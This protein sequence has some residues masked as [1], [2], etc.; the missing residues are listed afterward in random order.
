MRRWS[1]AFVL[2]SNLAFAA[3]ARA[4]DP[5]TLTKKDHTEFLVVPD[6]GGDSDTGIEVG[7]GITLARFEK[8]YRPY[9][10]RIDVLLG[11]SFKVDPGFRLVQHRYSARLD[12][13]G[14][15]GGKLRLDTRLAYLR[16]G[17][18]SWFGEGN[19]SN[20]SE[21]PVAGTSRQRD[22][23]LDESIRL[24]T[25]GRYRIG[26]AV[27]IAFFP[28]L[29]RESPGVFAG[30][31]LD[32]DIARGRVVGGGPSYLATLAAG[33][34]ID[35]R[36]EEF[37]PTRGIFYQLGVADTVGSADGVH[38]GEASATLMHYVPFG[39]R[40]IFASRMFASFKFGTIPFYELQQGGVFDPIYMVGGYRGIR[41]IRLGR[42]AGAVKLVSN[43]E[44][45]VFPIDP[46]KIMGKRMLIGFD[47][48]FDSGR[49]FKDYA[50]SSPE[51]GRKVGFKFGAGGG[52][53]FQWD[54]ANVFR[55]ELA[56]SPTHGGAP[57]FYFE[58]GVIF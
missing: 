30:T 49:V 9:R 28:H 35:T 13:P 57:L 5:V 52:V 44:L 2:A 29:R 1:L 20:G 12:S 8:G 36:D 25:L 56:S 50:I 11:T 27:E 14:L 23:Y 43:I 45:R 10:Y 58:N 24:R 16:Q 22:E 37:I 40:V 21:V 48:F 51:D 26:P 55:V 39:K 53:L 46:F 19:A 41:G 7:V 32:D 6:T 4:D 54:T 47:A 17:D 3:V 34:V 15:L 31:K 38:F 18:I 33:L 42:F